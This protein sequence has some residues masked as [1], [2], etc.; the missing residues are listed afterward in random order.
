MPIFQRPRFQLAMEDTPRR[1]FG[2]R[3]P[4]PIDEEEIAPEMQVPMEPQ[5]EPVKKEGFGQKLGRIFGMSKPEPEIDQFG[6]EKPSMPKEGIGAK[7]LNYL[8]PLAVGAIGGVPFHALAAAHAGDRNRQLERQKLFNEEQKEYNEQFAKM[9]KP[10]MSGLAKE[11]RDFMKMSP[12]EQQVAR[13][14]K[15]FDKGFVNPFDIQKFQYQM[16]KDAADRAMKRQE[17]ENPIP[18]N[19]PADKAALLAEGAQI[20]K[21]LE[22][23]ATT[24]SKNRNVGGP[25]WG[26]IHGNNPYAEK[27]QG[28]QAEINQVKQ[29]VGKFLEGG[30]LRK[31][32]EEKYNKI[33][34][35]I[36]DTPEVRAI[37]LEKLK[38]LTSDKYN[39]YLDSF[40]RS[41]Y[42]V[43]K[44]KPIGATQKQQQRQRVTPRDQ[45]AI[46]WAQNNPDNPDAQRIMRIHGIRPQT[47]SSR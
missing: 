18:E 31:E 43:R 27:T 42:D 7:A 26:R 36:N 19:L 32:D 17:R 40:G 38:K 1:I 20:P 44:Y 37:K 23:L 13:E 45:E 29:T 33:L 15:T 6:L 28:V 2:P 24:L 22:G 3:Q 39:E 34:P 4:L 41:R 35:T 8:L 21:L 11:V 30:V 14:L 46:E 5:A 25:I 10:E 12:Q 9:S 47:V 16:E